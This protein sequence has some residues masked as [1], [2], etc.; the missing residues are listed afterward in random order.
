MI[1]YLKNCQKTTLI[2]QLPDIINSNN[3]SIKNEFDWIFDSSLNRLTKS[4]Y[5]PT[6]SVKAHFG[7]FTNLI[8]DYI[9]IKN[10]NSVINTLQGEIDSIIRDS[11]D[12]LK[13]FIQEIIDSSD[14]SIHWDPSK[15][16]VMNHNL[17]ANRFNASVYDDY[18]TSSW[19]HDAGIIIYKND[20]S[21]VTVENELN[22]LGNENNNLNAKIDTTIN[23][24]NDVSTSVSDL[25]DM[26]INF[27]DTAGIHIVKLQYNGNGQTDTSVYV[28][29]GQPFG[30]KLK[31]P[32][33]STREY[34]GAKFIGWFDE[35]NRMYSPDDIVNLND[36]LI[37][38]ASW[39]L[40]Y[41]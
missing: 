9:T 28:A 37:L 34:D 32:D 41:Q 29:N 31:D 2:G 38:D 35:N 10:T 33:P 14:G 1:N 18:A 7:E 27:L 24:I 16:W 25:H 11:F 22:R 13:D 12:N 40:R 39:T 36:N 6:G 8:C 17:L 3:Q 20:P 30:P 21:V 5:A 15:D 19:A 23:D 26:F 4:V